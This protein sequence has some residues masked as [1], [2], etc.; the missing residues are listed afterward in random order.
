VPSCVENN[1]RRND[2]VDATAQGF[3]AYRSIHSGQVNDRINNI[4]AESKVPFLGLRHH[5]QIKEI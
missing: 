2:D 3:A 4:L 1:L 5:H